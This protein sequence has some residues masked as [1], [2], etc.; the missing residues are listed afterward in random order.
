MRKYQVQTPSKHSPLI[1]SHHPAYLGL[2][3]TTML[4]PVV[5]TLELLQCIY[6]LPLSIT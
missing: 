3:L 2:D 4:H 6:T 5:S 1:T